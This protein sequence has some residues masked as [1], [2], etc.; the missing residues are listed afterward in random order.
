MQFF[1]DPKKFWR[2]CWIG[3]VDLKTGRIRGVFLGDLNQLCS[4][5]ALV[6]AGGCKRRA[7]CAVFWSPKEVFGDCQSSD[8]VE[9]GRIRGLKP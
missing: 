3:I 6:F 9:T 7:T 5:T 8:I 4:K 1:G 2:C